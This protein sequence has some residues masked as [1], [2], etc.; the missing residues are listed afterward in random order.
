MEHWWNGTHRVKHKYS[1]RKVSQCHFVRHE[2][3]TDWFE[4]GPLP[5]SLFALN[6]MCTAGTLLHKQKIRMLVQAAVCF[7]LSLQYNIPKYAPVV[8]SLHRWNNFM[9]EVS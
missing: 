7:E 4:I 8:E 1:E 5:L 9:C 6:Y 3:H 2:C